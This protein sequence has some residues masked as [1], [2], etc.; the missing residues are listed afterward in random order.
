MFTAAIIGALALI[1]RYFVTPL[2]TD[3]ILVIRVVDGQTN[4]KIELARVLLNISGEPPNT[5]Q[6]G[7]DGAVSF[8]IPSEKMGQMTYLRIEK[9][10]YKTVVRELNANPEGMTVILEPIQ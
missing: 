8:L 2:Q 1:S 3:K 7:N 9:D 4:R 6:T 10:G 5:K